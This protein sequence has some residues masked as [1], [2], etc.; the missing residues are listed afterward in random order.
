[1]TVAVIVVVSVPFAKIVLRESD[2]VIVAASALAAPTSGQMQKMLIRASRPN[3]ARTPVRRC[4]F[5]AT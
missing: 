4:L 5:C 3:S 2:T 1:V